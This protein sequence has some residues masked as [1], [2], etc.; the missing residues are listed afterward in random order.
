[1]TETGDNQVVD[2]WRSPRPAMELVGATFRLYRRYPLLFLVLATVVIVPFEAI[3]LAAT[4]SGGFARG[5]AGVGVQLPLEFVNWVLVGPLISALHIHA[6]AEVRQGREPRIAAVARQ[7]L[8]VLPVV[9]AATIMSGLGIG[10]G[11]LLLV[12][13]GIILAFRWA[14]AAQAAAIEHE[15]W[16]PALRRSRELTAG[17]Y[18]HI[19]VFFL[20]VG[21]ITVVPGL[22]GGAAFGTHDTSVL[23]FACGLVVHVVVASFAALAGAL[24]YFDLVTRHD[25]PSLSSGSTEVISMDDGKPPTEHHLDPRRYSDEERP[26]AW[27]V[28]PTAPHLMR[29]WVSRGDPPYW[30]GSTRTSR[31][32]RREW[33]QLNDY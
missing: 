29:F 26:A 23:S 10:L 31:Q 17:N 28:D 15:G 22:L 21:L 16:L 27:Y 24:L 11:L 13:P 20:I 12:V 5:S 4:G 6:A 7:G 8:A 18:G 14:V 3:T 33:R 32:I 9:A 19:F 2:D 25:D 1:M 30:E